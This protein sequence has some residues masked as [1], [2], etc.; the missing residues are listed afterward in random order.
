MNI[1][2]MIC[3]R[4]SFEKVRAH[5]GSVLGLEFPSRLCPQPRV[6][7][8]A[9]SSAPS[10]HQGSV[11]RPVYFTQVMDVVFKEAQKGLPWDCFA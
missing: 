11:L 2:T 3:N 1:Q 5:Q 9:L 7:I 8:K 10:F 4:S 6:S